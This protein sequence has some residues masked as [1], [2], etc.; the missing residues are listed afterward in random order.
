M[1]WITEENYR[2]EMKREAE[3]DLAKR[4]SERFFPVTQSKDGR[5]E[6]L[7]VMCYAAD[8]PKGVLVISH[9]FTES[10]PKY[11]ELVYYFLQA[12]YHVY[13]PEHMGHGQSYRLTE[14]PSLVHVDT[15]KRYVR[16]LLAFCHEIRKEHPD[17]P[18]SLYAHSMGGGIGACAAAFEPALFHRVV[19]SSPMIRPLTGNVPW[20]LA[21][22]IAQVMCLFDKAE[23]YVAG[24]KPYDG[25]ESFEESAS[26]SE[27]RFARYQEIRSS[28]QEFQTNAASYGWL[29]SAIRM[30]IYLQSRGWKRIAS[31]ILIFQS[32]RDQYVS[33]TA[34]KRF[35]DKIR[36]KG[37]APRCEYVVIHGTKHEIY[38]SPDR[39]L[40][41]YVEQILS[42]L[43]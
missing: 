21:A 40:Q 20:P 14:D 4:R 31:P 29:L 10:T 3:P 34:L 7:H 15:W 11:D 18:L 8:A 16:D 33:L 32:E 9:G 23:K 42:F 19:L 17:L 39:I 37:N 28:R 1:R 24:Q 5:D 12:G 41:N 30:S 38:S 2:E 35:T 43:E 22:L 6:S 13:V 26:S 27:P 25:K 36:K